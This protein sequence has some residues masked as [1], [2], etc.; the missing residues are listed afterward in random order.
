MRRTKN[1]TSSADRKSADRYDFDSTMRRS[2]SSSCCAMEKSQKKN[3]T[4]VLFVA[5]SDCSFAMITGMAWIVLLVASSAMAF[6]FTVDRL[7]ATHTTELEHDTRVSSQFTTMTD[8]AHQ[9][10][11]VQAWLSGK[12]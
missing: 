12:L 4:F 9:H 5:S 1:E 11:V 2:S 10:T 3:R 6:A 8:A 7:G